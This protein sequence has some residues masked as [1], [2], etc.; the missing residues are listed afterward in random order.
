MDT[1][2]R[3]VLLTE[4]THMARGGLVVLKPDIAVTPTVAKVCDQA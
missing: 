3:N 2:P 4:N 1:V